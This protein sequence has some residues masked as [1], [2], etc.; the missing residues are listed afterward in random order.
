MSACH[1][2]RV[3]CRTRTHTRTLREPDEL[4]SDADAALVERLDGDLVSDTQPAQNAVRAHFNVLKGNLA[5]RRGADA[6]L[7]LLQ[8][9]TN[10]AEGQKLFNNIE[11]PIAGPFC[12][13]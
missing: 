2:T 1:A 4:R 6:Q 7:V 13:Q 9:S 11:A 5:R 3:H 12:R 8:P 10:I